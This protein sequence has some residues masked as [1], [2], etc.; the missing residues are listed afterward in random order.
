MAYGEMG[1]A[2]KEAAK[3]E[4]KIKTDGKVIAFGKDTAFSF[5]RDAAISFGDGNA[6]AFGSGYARCFGKGNA[7]SIR[8]NA[9]S[10]EGIAISYG[11]G[12]AYSERNEAIAKGN[13]K[14]KSFRKYKFGLEFYKKNTNIENRESFKNFKHDLIKKGIAEKIPGLIEFEFKSKDQTKNNIFKSKLKARR[15]KTKVSGLSR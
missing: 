6:K 9:F 2:L 14:T 7:E 1:R 11:N 12:F 13:G 8:G 3:F 5:G 4:G 15:A 10:N